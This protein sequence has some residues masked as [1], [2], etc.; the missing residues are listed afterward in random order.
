M[1]SGIFSSISRAYCAQLTEYRAQC[2]AILNEV[3]TAI[4]QLK[5]TKQKYDF[6]STKTDAMHKACEN[7][8]ED[9]V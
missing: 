7:L 9:Q 8:L 5:Q 3:S 2:D 1:H 4:D 6:V